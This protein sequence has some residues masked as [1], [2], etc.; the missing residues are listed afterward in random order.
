M[1]IAGKIIGSG[2]ILLVCVVFYSPA[3]AD[4]GGLANEVAALWIQANHEAENSKKN[5]CWKKSKGSEIKQA[6][7]LL[8]EIEV[9]W[10]L[11]EANR[12]KS[13]SRYEV[14]YAL[15]LRGLEHRMGNNGYSLAAMQGQDDFWTV[16]TYSNNS[17][18]QLSF[19]YLEPTAVQSILDIQEQELFDVIATALAA[20]KAQGSFSVASMTSLVY[21]T[22]PFMSQDSIQRIVNE[23]TITY[24]QGIGSDQKARLIALS[25]LGQI[26]GI[27]SPGQRASIAKKF[28]ATIKE[29][30]LQD[31]DSRTRKT[32]SKKGRSQS[33]AL[34][35]LW[36][37]IALQQTLDSVE[38]DA[39]QKKITTLK[40]VDPQLS[41]SLLDTINLL[42]L[43]KDLSWSGNLDKAATIIRTMILFEI[44]TSNT[45]LNL[46]RPINRKNT[47]ITPYPLWLALVPS[48]SELM[49][50]MENSSGQL[51]AESYKNS[52]T[53]SRDQ[54]VSGVVE[55]GF[56]QL[57]ENVVN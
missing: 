11:L 53:F 55:K 14:L 35:K 37:Y 30:L 47:V 3:K 15:S 36:R 19:S 43:A 40:G 21:L 56:W 32:L 9:G 28:P 48:Y 27:L 8:K 42:L 4:M 41:F 1:N 50:F 31:I 45:G 7:Q 39:L 17:E 23:L 26:M 5:R 54:Y 20:C 29:Q 16:R 12:S 6:F 44:G 49:R 51:T 10:W 13:K 34:I 2:L 33:L 57:F 46:T 52:R 25:R 22:L 18:E 38:V 24:Q